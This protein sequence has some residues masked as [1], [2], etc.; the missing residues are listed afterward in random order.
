MANR[1]G[2]D[3]AKV[4]EFSPFPVRHGGKTTIC[5]RTLELPQGRL[6][7]LFRAR[8]GRY[9]FYLRKGD[10]MKPSLRLKIVILIG[11][12]VLCTTLLVLG[13]QQADPLVPGEL[14]EPGL[15]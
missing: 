5:R 10:P 1:R 12:V 13:D 15:E 14:T 8:A 7:R 11:Y 3:I 4:Y 2:D 9:H 6:I